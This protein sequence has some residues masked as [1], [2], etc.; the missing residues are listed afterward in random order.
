VEPQ[1]SNSLNLRGTPARELIPRDP[2]LC[3]RWHL[4]SATSPLHRWNYHPEYEIHY[5]VRGHGRFVVGDYIDSY[6][7]GQLVLMGPNVPHN[8]LDDEA[9]KPNAQYMVFQFLPEWVDACRKVMPEVTDIGPLFKRS[10]Y[11]IEFRSD[12]AVEGARLLARIGET[13]GAK[14]LSAIFG[15][16]DLMA[17]SPETEQRILSQAWISPTIDN[18]TSE[19]IDQAFAYVMKNLVG[20]VRLSKAAELVGLSESAF[21]KCFKRAAGQT[22]T[23][24]V[25]K[26]RLTR[27]AELLRHTDMTVAA[28]HSTV[29]YSNLSNFNRQFR[30]Y[31]RVAPTEYRKRLR[32]AAA[33]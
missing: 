32:S 11:G 20:E 25:R 26:L 3:G 5:V 16:F 12:T 30:A 21:S 23:D 27:A 17:D 24:A 14:R 22:F 6:C 1:V 10:L 15:L 4:H 8:W 7:S 19:I 29:G 31:Y 33:T 28:I 13:R 9:E 2:G 18:T